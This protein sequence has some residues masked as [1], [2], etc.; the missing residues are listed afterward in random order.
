MTA[1]LTSLKVRVIANKRS[2]PRKPPARGRK[3]ASPGKKQAA[4]GRKPAARRTSHPWASLMLVVYTALVVYWMFI[5]FGREARAGGPL[6]YNLVPLRTIQLYLNPDNG[7]PVMIRMINLLGNVAVFIPFGY[8][9]P[10]VKPSYRSFTG[11]LFSSALCIAVLECMQMV[12]HVG[13]LDIDDLLLNV[14]GVGIGYCLY[15]LK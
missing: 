1:R 12:L 3:P 2:S 11:M 6:Q 14:L 7:V 10:F 13:S 15:K 4:R 5:G 8:L 9:L